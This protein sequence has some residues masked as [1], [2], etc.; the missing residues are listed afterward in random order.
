MASYV[1]AVVMAAYYNVAKILSQAGAA[2]TS[3]IVFDGE[4]YLQ[5]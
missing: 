2:K 1:A 4:L 5:L 3:D